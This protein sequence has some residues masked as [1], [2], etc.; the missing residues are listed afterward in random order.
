MSEVIVIG[1]DDHGLTERFEVA[2][3]S[4]IQLDGRPIGA[5]LDEGGIDAASVLVLTDADLASIIPVA[6]ERNAPIAI[7]L[8]SS[9]RLPPYASAQADLAID[10]ALVDP[11]EVVDAVIDRI[12]EMA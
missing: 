7:V 5:D 6:K 12:A 2:G 1:S 9:G 11:D 3:V 10:P 8:Y 4:A